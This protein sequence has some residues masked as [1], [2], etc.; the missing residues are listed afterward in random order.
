MPGPYLCSIQLMI[1]FVKATVV[2]SISTGADFAVPRVALQRA[3]ESTR[4]SIVMKQDNQQGENLP[5]LMLMLDFVSA[6]VHG[7]RRP[8]CCRREFHRRPSGRPS[9]DPARYENH[10]PA[11]RK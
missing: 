11:A 6:T 9:L 5:E 10:R 8:D 3:S 7:L 4:V 1:V 2:T